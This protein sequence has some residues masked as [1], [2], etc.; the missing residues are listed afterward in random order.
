MNIKPILNIMK[1]KKISRSDLSRKLGVTRQSI[2]D[3]LK[4]WDCGSEPK[5]STLNKWESALGI[6]KGTLLKHL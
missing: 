5:V 3:I 1:D 4:K 2:T 6:K